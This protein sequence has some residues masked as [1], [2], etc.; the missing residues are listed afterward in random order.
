MSVLPK[1]LLC[2]LYFISKGIVGS[3][4]CGLQFFGC[5]WIIR[6]RPLWYCFEEYPVHHGKLNLCQPISD[7]SGFM[8]SVFTIVWVTSEGPEEFASLGSITSL[9]YSY[10]E[11]GWVCP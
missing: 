6:S 9:I 11:M 5:L 8:A 4:L 2:M 1:C 7:R 10:M 3:S